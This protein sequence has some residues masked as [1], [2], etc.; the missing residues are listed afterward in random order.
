LRALTRPTLSIISLCIYCLVD[1]NAIF[2]KF[3]RYFHVNAISPYDGGYLLS[4]RYLCSAIALA[5]N[6]TVKWRVQGETGGDF[7][8]GNGT[9]FCYQHDIRA[10]P[11]QPAENATSILLS[12]HDN[13]NSPIFNNSIPSTGKIME[14][15]FES[16][17]VSLKQEYLNQSGPIYSTAQGNM[18]RL[19]SGN[20][21]ISHGWIPVSEEFSYTGEILSTFQ[22]GAAV[23]KPGGG[24]FSAQRGTLSYRAFKQPWLGCPTTKPDVV[25]EMSSNGTSVNVSWNGAT[26]VQAWEIYG[27]SNSTA[28]ECLTTV[29]KTGFETVTEIQAVEYV[30]GTPVLG[31]ACGTMN[32]SSD[33]VAVTG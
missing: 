9:N 12:M 26:E 22:Y 18:Q 20:V 15:D 32:V 10:I 7:V 29:P 33:V 1:A 11:E 2:F 13:Y 25:A 8:L 27:G 23:P 19:A 28:L 21:F 31:P 30:Q 17:S 6:G 24:F 5:K 16:M 14:L 4:S 3:G